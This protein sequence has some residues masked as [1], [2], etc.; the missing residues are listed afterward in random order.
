MKKWLDKVFRPWFIVLLIIA[1]THQL[2]EKLLRMH[3]PIIDSYLDP[4]LLMPILLHLLLWEQRLLFKKGDH[5]VFSWVQLTILFL[6][7]S[8]ITEYLFPLWQPRFTADFF[9]VLCYALGTIAFGVFF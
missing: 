6:V 4:I 3:I 8:F 1:F 2:M 7:V 5:F 9:D